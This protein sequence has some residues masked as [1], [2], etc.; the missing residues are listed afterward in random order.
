MA[1]RRPRPILLAAALAG[2]CAGLF[3]AAF[4]GILG[5]SPARAQSFLGTGPAER[6]TVPPSGD[7][8]RPLPPPERPPA[9]SGP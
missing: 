4:A 7:A 3:A 8:L 2:V 1:P 9:A 6:L 5:G